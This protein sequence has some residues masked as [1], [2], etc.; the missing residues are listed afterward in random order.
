MIINRNQTNCRSGFSLIE[1]VVTIAI[2]MS[3]TIAVVVM[4]RG[5]I[6]VR[7]GLSVESKITQR[8]NNAMEIVA[9]DVSHAILISKNDKTRYSFDRNM[10]TVFKVESGSE[11]DKLMLTTLSN[12]PFRANSHESDQAY[13]VYQVSDSTDVPGRKNLYRGIMQAT[14]KDLKEEPPMR[15]LARNIKR[16]K[17]IGWRGDQWLKDKWDSDRSDTA[18]KIPRMIRVEIGTWADDPLPGDT[19]DP[20]MEDSMV[21]LKTVITPPLSL[22]FNDVK[23]QVSSINWYNGRD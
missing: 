9:R 8:L 5:A 15:L 4:M 10:K 17:I 1:V 18:N 19:P 23:Q 12:R 6:D 20:A 14:S 16:F 2:L 11:V 3:L 13:V 21:E 22:G 7:Q